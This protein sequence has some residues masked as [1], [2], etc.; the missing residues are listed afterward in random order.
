MS[1][2]KQLG[3]INHQWGSLNELMLPIN[4]RGLNFSDGIFETILIWEGKARLLKEHL[5]RWEKSAKDL[6]M[7]SPPK[8]EWLNPLI[9]EAIARCELEEM[10]GSIRLNWSRGNN[11]NRGIKITNE[12]YEKS[13]HRFWLEINE[14]QNCFDPISTMISCYEKRNANSRINQY[15]TFAYGQSIQAQIEAKKH[16]FDDALLEN[17]TG[18]ICS[19]TTANLIIKRNGQLLTPHKRSGCLPGIIRQK[20]LDLGITQEASLSSIPKANDEWLL[21]NSLSCRPIY[22]VNDIPLKKFVGAK[23]LWLSIYQI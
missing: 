7:A 11:K 21:I 12:E 19:G 18:E 5:N 6:G 3:W 4:D 22:T 17:T 15:K 10:M 9:E 20:S 8:E 14:I 1:R 16:G 23:D 13:N 2:N